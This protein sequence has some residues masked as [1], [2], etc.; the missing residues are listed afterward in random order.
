MKRI[1]TII[2][3]VIH[4]ECHTYITY[5]NITR[6]LHFL[7]ADTN[8]NVCILGQEVGLGGKKCHFFRKF[9]VHI[10]RTPLLLKL[11]LH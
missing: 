1:I 7:P 9:Y 4:I 6:N 11:F 2:K 8:A 5:A 3:N 10:I